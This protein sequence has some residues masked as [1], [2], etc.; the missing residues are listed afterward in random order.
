MAILPSLKLTA[1]TWKFTV[2]SL[3][4]HL[5]DGLFSGM[6]AVKLSGSVTGFV[7]SRWSWMFSLSQLHC[8]GFRLGRMLYTGPCTCLLRWGSNSLWGEMGVP[9]IAAHEWGIQDDFFPEII[10]A[11]SFGFGPNQREKASFRSSI[12]SGW[13]FE[14]TRLAFSQGFRNV[15]SWKLGKTWFF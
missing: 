10:Q 15:H 14:N 7:S 12:I 2:G 9:V 8:F 1:R 3:L 13:W 6:F 11:T 4:F 5:W